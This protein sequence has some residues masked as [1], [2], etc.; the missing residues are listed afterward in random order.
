M[1]FKKYPVGQV[2]PSQLLLTYGV[3][4]IIDLPHMATLVMGL[5]DWNTTHAKEIFEERLLSTIQTVLGPQV[6]QLLSPPASDT[7]AQTP[8]GPGA[9]VGVPV[10]P[11]PRWMVCPRCHL[12]ASIDSGYFQLTANPYYPDRTCYRHHNC[13]KQPI[14]L[15]SRFMIACEGGHL[16]DFPYHHFVHGDVTCN[17]SLR[18]IERGVSGEPSDIYIKCEICGKG[19]AMSEA[20]SSNEDRTYQPECRGRRPHLRDF[21]N[22][23]QFQPARTI[24]LAASNTWF[25]LIYTLLAL[26]TTTDPLGQLIEVHWDTWREA[27]NVEDV[28]IYRRL[29][30][31]REHFAGYSDQAIWEQIERKQAGEPHLAKPADLK[32]PE[33]QILSNPQSAPKAD[34]FEVT[35]MGSPKGYTNIIEQVVLVERLREVRALLGFTR[36]ESL[37]DYTEEEELPADHIMPLTRHHPT[38]VPAAEVRG[39]GIFIQFREEAIKQWLQKLAIERHDIIFRNAHIRW[40]TARRIANPEANY[41]HIRYILLHTFAHAF[42]RQLTLECGYTAASIRERIYAQSADREGGAMAGILLYTAA[43]DSEGTLG[44]LVSLGK[45]LGIH[46]S[47]ALEDLRNCA[48]DPLCAEHISLEDQTLHGAACHA[49]MFIPETSCERGNRYL[50]RSVLVPT[51]ERDT[52]AFFKD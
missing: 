2:R 40:R 23:C 38:W 46:I 20:F 6:T 19:R 5:D 26:P 11:F 42:M 49:C 29:A 28:G 51:V 14:V 4:S 7:I 22:T 30:K 35:P 47:G 13:H 3:G 9:L 18:M 27:Q 12:L 48:S 43:S 24:L 50:D 36:L 16:D 32:V 25:P 44:G 1:G 33:W 21:E 41:P 17:S 37:S 15:P 10:A 52:L 39:E 34:D 8:L 45:N 31:L